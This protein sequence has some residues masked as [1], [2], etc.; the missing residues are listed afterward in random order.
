MDSPLAKGRRKKSAWS[1]TLMRQIGELEAH[2]EDI[3]YEVA[4]A[5]EKEVRHDVMSHVYAYGMAVPHCKAHHTCWRYVM[6]CGDNTD[7]I[8]MREH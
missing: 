1:G 7:I 4:E 5:R 8:I 6:L 2:V 3:N